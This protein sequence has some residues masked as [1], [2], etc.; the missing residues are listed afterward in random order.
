MKLEEVLKEMQS[1]ELI[2]YIVSVRK[3]QSRFKWQP[4]R[5]QYFDIWIDFYLLT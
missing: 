4:I 2:F 3:N 5:K 1:L